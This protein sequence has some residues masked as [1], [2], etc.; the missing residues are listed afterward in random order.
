MPFVGHFGRTVLQE[1]AGGASHSLTLETG[2]FAIT[3]IALN[4]RITTP[5]AQG[6]FA[7]NGVALNGRISSPLAVGSFVWTGN[8][9][10][11]FKSIILAL[12]TG[13]FAVTGQELHGRIN[14]PL[15]AG[16]FEVTGFDA[17]FHRA[18]TL[19]LETGNFEIIGHDMTLIY[20][21]RIVEAGGGKVKKR[22]TREEYLREAAEQILG[23]PT[24]EERKALERKN[25]A[26]IRA[27]AERNRQA[28][29]E[30]E[31]ISLLAALDLL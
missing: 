2:A 4:G 30:M 26:K 25:R 16:S 7:I 21:R 13:S 27:L 17:E 8:D 22:K 23:A 11:F 10:E 9:G 3:G 5:V 14:S 19:A 15:D 18:F 20:L 28:D 1:D 12:E 29:E 6:S 24:P 31:I